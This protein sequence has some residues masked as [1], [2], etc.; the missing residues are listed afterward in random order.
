[1]GKGSAVPCK[2]FCFFFIF[3]NFYAECCLLICT[4]AIPKGR[5]TCLKMLRHW[6]IAPFL[7]FFAM[8]TLGLPLVALMSSVEQLYPMPKVQGKRHVAECIPFCVQQ[9]ECPSIDIYSKCRHQGFGLV[10]NF[11]CSSLCCMGLRSR[12]I[13]LVAIQGQQSNPVAFF[14][15]ELSQSCY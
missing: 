3:I 2:R 8:K 5:T 7:Q 14:G 4:F 12:C 15:A 9:M 6:V 13:S 1:M 10:P 11:L